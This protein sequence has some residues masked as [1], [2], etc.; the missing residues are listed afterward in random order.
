MT[1]LHELREVDRVEVLCLDDNVVDGL[2]ASTEVAKRAPVRPKDGP[3][4]PAPLQ[5]SGSAPRSLRAE[6]GFCALVTTYRDGRSGRILLDAGMTGDVVVHNMGV[7]RIDPKTIDAVVLSHGHF[8]HSAGLGGLAAV[9]R[10]PLP[11]IL[12]PDAWLERRCGPVPI[13]NLSRQAVASAG[14]EIVETRQPTYPVDGSLL[15]TG[16]VERTTNFEVGFPGH[17]SFRNGEWVADAAI[18]DD[19]AVVV[20]VRGKGLVV[21]SGCGHSGI[22]NILRYACRLTGVERVHAVMGGFHLSGAAFEPGIPA[23]VTAIRGYAPEWV[24]PMHCTGWKAVHAIASAM[25]EQFIQNSVG[26]TYTF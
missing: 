6:H 21:L 5:A 10:R 25:P 7:L 18:L 11:L 17:E 20:N 24:V 8:D 19:Q 23:T 12:H 9:L 4:D 2:L 16:E 14:F 1:E 13:P 15:V 3:S 26:T 22:I